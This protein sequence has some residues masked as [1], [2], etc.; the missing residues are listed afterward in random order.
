[1]LK[2]V[3]ILILFVILNF[4][5]INLLK[6]KKVKHFL[7]KFFIFFLILIITY[8]FY[9]LTH[10]IYFYKKLLNLLELIPIFLSNYFLYILVIKKNIYIN[11][12][13]KTF[14]LNKQQ[15]L[16][17]NKIKIYAKR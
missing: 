8:D 13:N 5:E 3:F 10:S 12:F 17:L 14:F 7:V 15:Q 1:M 4:F 11:I 9:I 16:N 6:I 2:L